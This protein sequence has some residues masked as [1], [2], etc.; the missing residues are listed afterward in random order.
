LSTPRAAPAGVAPP[1]ATLLAGLRYL[2]ISVVLF[3]GIWPITKAGLAHATPLW[4]AFNRAAMAALVVG[5]LLAAQGRLRWPGR[6]DWPSVLTIGLLQLGGFFA[7]SHLALDYIP[8]GRT[9]I[10]GSVTIFWLIP[11]SVWVLGERVSA[12]QWLAVVAG[13]A[14]VVVLMQ[15]WAMAEAGTLALLPGYAMLLVASLFWSLAILVTRRWPPRRP[16]LDLL[17]W[18]FGLGAVFLLPLALGREPGGGIGRAAWPHALFVGAVAAPLGTWATIEAGR[19]LS[20]ITAS[21]GFLLVPTLG[22]AISSLW[23]GEA[24]GWDLLAAGALIGLSMLLAARG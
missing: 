24:V 6:A 22:V 16:V 23:L 12:R 4:F 18:C 20:G 19:R 10:L 17:P 5:L 3:G 7:L 11:L 9:A 21:L 15:P 14:G 13:L 2:G 8:A 1:P